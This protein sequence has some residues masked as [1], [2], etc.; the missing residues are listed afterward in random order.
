[1][2]RLII[3]V[4]LIFVSGCTPTPADGDGPVSAA[5]TVFTNADIYTMDPE[6]PRADALAVRD[7][8]I[9]AVGG[10]TDILKFCGPNT[11]KVDLKGRVVVPGLIDSH[12]HLASLGSLVTGSL[13]LRQTRSYD[14]ML[15]AVKEAVAKA[16]KGDWITGG[17]WDQANWGQKKLPTHHRLSEVSPDNPVWLTRVDGHAGLANARAMELAGI[18][19]STPN[20]R[21]GEILRDSKG[22][23]TGIFVDNAKSLIIRAMPYSA[24]SSVED[25]VLAAQKRCLAVGLTGV[26]DAGVSPAEIGLY[27]KLADDHKLK[28]RIYAMVDS[29]SAVPYFEK[30]K[31]LIGYGDNRI[32]VRAVKCMVDG[33]MGS[34]GAWLLADYS[35]RKGYRGLPGQQPEFIL[36]IS[37]AALKHGYQVCTHAIGDRG[38]RETIDVYEKA[39]KDNPVKDHRF[40]VEHAQMVSLEDIPRFAELG[41]IPSMQQTHCTSDMRWAEDRVGPERVKG[42][43]A[44]AKFLRA[45]CR[46]AGGSDF[47]VESENPLLGFYAAVTRAN[48]EGLPSGGWRPEDLMTREE[49]LRSF[50]IDAAYAAFEE[51]IKGSLEVGKLAD[52]VVLSKNIM[53]CAAAEI[54][55]TEC[56][57]TVI[58]GE[59]VYEKKQ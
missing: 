44:W 20:P 38:N 42:C 46:I 2:T 9:I 16:K 37:R 48:A 50:T 51:K 17:R 28:L 58:G 45:G 23:A 43:Y 18:D 4:L 21:G 26:H 5:D 8:K 30:N 14:K 15:E 33:A 39:L 25:Y 3:T 49:A 27:K 34:R 56:L 59:M 35:D 13:D 6:R 24:G 29:G 11:G 10:D 55:K 47:P 31:P 12:A 53:T 22:K 52:F 1:M 40:R 57:M 36:K 7:G 41:I 32:T 54:L 19:D